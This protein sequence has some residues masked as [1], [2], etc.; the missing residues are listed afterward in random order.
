MKRIRRA[1]GF[2]L[3]ELLVVIAIIAILA[4]LLLPALASAKRRAQ[5]AKCLSQMKQLVLSD[6]MYVS[7]Y[8]RS[9]QDEAPDGTQGMWFLNM[10]DYYSKATNILFCPVAY[11]ASTQNAGSPEGTAA[12]PYFKTDGTQPYF[13]TYLMNGWFCTSYKNSGVGSGD[14]I[15]QVLPG[16]QQG[17][18]GY[19]INPASMCQNPAQSPV[20][21]EGIWA[22]AWPAEKDS[23]ARNTYKG[24][25]GNWGAEMGRT[26]ISRHGCTP[27]PGTGWTAANQMPVGGINV[28]CFDGHAE[29]SRLPNLWSYYWHYNWNSSL[30]AI[31]TLQ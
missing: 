28:A 1:N 9:M 24:N 18:T 2:T 30:A 3:I 19:F 4:A 12:M 26:C 29:Y 13:G 25:Q 7:D 20:F 16:G 17:S 14:G 6:I 22:D 5:E 31:G 23:G 10:I 27:G 8:G 21:S 15:G 11:L